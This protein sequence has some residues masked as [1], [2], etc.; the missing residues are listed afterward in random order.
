M[1]TK[2]T[3]HPLLQKE[4]KSLGTWNDWKALWGQA[5]YNVQLL[6]LLHCAFDVQCYRDENEERFCFLLRAADG[7]AAPT[8]YWP[9]GQV[10]GEAEMSWK[11]REKW[12]EVRKP[13]AEK[14]FQVLCD[15]Y[16]KSLIRDDHENQ[17]LSYLTLDMWKT[18]LWFFCDQERHL[19]GPN[20]PRE[21]DTSHH[22]K[23]ARGYAR[24]FARQAWLYLARR[25]DETEDDFLS[26]CLPHMQL[27]HD[28]GELHFLHD[29]KHK[30]EWDVA[31]LR[32]FALFDKEGK[33]VYRDAE[34]AVNTYPG[35]ILLVLE[36][37]MRETDRKRRVAEAERKQRE[38]ERELTEARK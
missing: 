19:V 32:R 21:T 27:L 20:L 34:E 33:Q 15:R 2:E 12:L 35:R 4:F 23:V 6:S 30:C 38:A 24:Q 11:D 8:S 3:T 16:F 29:E 13:I 22:A 37:R 26:R 7:H 10:R 9:R 17:S 18:L 28:L 5:T 25:N 14:A 1:D 31:L 36:A